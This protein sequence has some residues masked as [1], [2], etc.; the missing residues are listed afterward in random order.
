MG[1]EPRRD[2]T[3]SLTAS[4]IPLPPPSTSPV[5]LRN[6][7]PI[8]MLG[9]S[10]H[11]QGPTRRPIKKITSDSI[12]WIPQN[13]SC[14]KQ[15]SPP[16]SIFS[17]CWCSY[18][19]SLP[20]SLGYRTLRI[21]WKEDLSLPCKSSPFKCSQIKSFLL[22]EGKLQPR[23]TLGSSSGELR[24]HSHPLQRRHSKGRKESPAWEQGHF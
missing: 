10:D 9:S 1:R 4:A 21:P 2:H 20:S 8:L 3:L 12:Q 15:F 19:V 14:W 17:Q 5:Q 23:P 13:D 6:P 11:T 24:A 22:I 7:S 16:C 18:N